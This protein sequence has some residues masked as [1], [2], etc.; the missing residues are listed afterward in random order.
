MKTY[1]NKS[2]GQVLPVEVPSSD[3]LRLLVQFC[4]EVQ[5]SCAIVHPS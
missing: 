5:G 1:M 4:R 3:D 2:M